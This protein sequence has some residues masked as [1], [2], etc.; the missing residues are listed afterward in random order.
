MFKKILLLL[1]FIGNVCWAGEPD[2]EMSDT[3]DVLAQECM[4]AEY[5]P[6]AV[7]ALA[8]E[9][10]GQRSPMYRYRDGKK[11]PFECS[12]CKKCFSSFGKYSDHALRIHV[13]QA[14]F[15]CFAGCSKKF[16]VPAARNNH[17]KKIHNTWLSEY[18][19][20]RQ[21]LDVD[22]QIVFRLLGREPFVN[23]EV[24]TWL[25]CSED[26]PVIFQCCVQPGVCEKYFNEKGK[27]L[28]HLLR[29]LVQSVF[30]CPSCSAPFY[31]PSDEYRHMRTVHG[32]NCLKEIPDLKRENKK[33]VYSLIRPNMYKV[34]RSS[35]SDAAHAVVLI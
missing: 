15:P 8:Q 34:I 23:K 32:E 29:H 30:V 2:V 31:T 6:V 21:I 3:L 7:P 22:R 13:R 27:I 25:Q 20:R 35:S 5:L 24:A 12:V 28:D 4:D 16:V 19:L 1:C 17:C 18:P 9:V 26:F 14:L 33:L 10:P 11:F